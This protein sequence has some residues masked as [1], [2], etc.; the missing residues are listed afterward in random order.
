MAIRYDFGK[1]TI[2]F[3]TKVLAGLGGAHIYN[4]QLTADHDN[5]CL[6]TRGDYV[7]LDLYKEGTTAPKFTGV[8]REKAG[9]GSYYVEVK[10]VGT[11]DEA[12]LFVY[13][14]ETGAEDY[15]KR[16]TNPAN[17]FNAKDDVVAGMTL[18][19]GDIILISEDAFSQKP[20][21][22]KEITGFADGKYTVATA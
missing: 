8:I 11:G 17:F 6:V 10:T 1:H 5:G 7:E 22:G 14:P 19:P 13:M 4:I 3:P 12:P 21:V 2:A 9:N 15:S 16:F 18:V 20:Q